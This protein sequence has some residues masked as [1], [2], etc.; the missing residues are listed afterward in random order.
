MRYIFRI[1]Y[2]SEIEYNL[3]SVLKSDYKHKIRGCWVK[4]TMSGICEYKP[5]KELTS[6]I[7]GFNDK[8]ISVHNIGSAFLADYLGKPCGKESGI[9]YY[10]KPARQVVGRNA[11]VLYSKKGLEYLSKYDDWVTF[12][13]IHILYDS[14]FLGHRILGT[15]YYMTDEN[16]LILIVGSQRIKYKLNE[17]IDGFNT[18]CLKLKYSGV[19]AWN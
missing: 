15:T 6:D 5:L 18:F 3:C 9:V 17:G 13:A 12:D 4:D 19:S 8:Y 2:K 16:Y 11:G 1:S 14:I 7:I 10:D